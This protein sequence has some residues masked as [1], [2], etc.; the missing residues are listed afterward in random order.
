MSVVPIFRVTLTL[1]DGRALE[2]AFSVS[3][4]ASAPI[5]SLNWLRNA[6]YQFRKKL[7]AMLRVADG[8]PES[9]D[10]G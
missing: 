10:V 5:G 7:E 4:R 3:P 9:G 6:E 2:G 8:K 1:P